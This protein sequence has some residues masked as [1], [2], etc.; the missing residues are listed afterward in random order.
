[1]ALP[2]DGEYPCLVEGAQGQLTIS[3]G[4]ARLANALGVDAG[5]VLVRL[6]A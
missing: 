6:L 1:M 4:Q 2:P 5:T 3:G